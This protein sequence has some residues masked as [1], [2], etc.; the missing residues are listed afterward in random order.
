MV[1]IGN[2]GFSNFENFFMFESDVFSGNELD[3]TSKKNCLSKKKM[4]FRKINS[5]LKFL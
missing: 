3:K 5:G 4:A 1:T 2:Y